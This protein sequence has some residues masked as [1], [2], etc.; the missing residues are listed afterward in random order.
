LGLREQGKSAA[1]VGAA[2]RKA[3]QLKPDL[4]EAH[5]ELGTALSAQGKLAEAEAAHRKAIQL[6]PSLAVAHNSLGIC[7]ACQGKLADAEAAFRKAVQLRPDSAKAQ[8]NLGNALKQQGRLDEAVA[9]LRQAIRLKK[10]LPDAHY[11]LA[12]ALQAQGR[13]QEAVAEFRE[14]I[15]LKEDF[16][17]AHHGL[18]SALVRRG[19]LDEAITAY[20]EAIRLKKDYAEAHCN[21]G[22]VL[23]ARGQLEAALASLRRGHELGSK[24][25]EWPHPSAAR[26]QQC[27][28]LIELDTKL[29][30]VLRGE[31]TPA[32]ARECLELAKLCQVPSKRLYAAAAHFYG[33]AF[34]AEPK[35]A[36]DLGAFHRYN[37]ACA[38][39]LAGCGHGKDADTL[40]AKERARLRRQA[41][42]W[43]GADLDGWRRLLDGEA[44]SA[45]KVAQTMA[46][47]LSDPDFNGVRGAEALAKLPQAE[48]RG[49]EQLWQEVEALRK[50][51]AGRP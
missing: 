30:A 37:A 18:G 9:E 46:H 4:A 28:R 8:A 10:D 2:H 21:L 41:L 3:I 42:D 40:D 20:R 35:Q 25:P 27:E 48:R 43:L 51:A 34:T 26:V 14:A 11:F 19:Q 22:N 15:Q 29:T 47:W 1:V 5:D 13:V 31:K 50:K 24:N 6:K 45:P 49:W 33:D 7:L 23:L 16:P 12:N 44:G 17:E 32:G 38:G 36:D 39:A